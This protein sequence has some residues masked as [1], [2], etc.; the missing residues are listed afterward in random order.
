MS[1]KGCLGVLRF[2][3]ILRKPGLGPRLVGSPIAVD[4][5]FFDLGMALPFL[6]LIPTTLTIYLLRKALGQSQQQLAD[7]CQLPPPGI[8][9]LVRFH[10]PGSCCI[11]DTY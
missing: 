3:G 6:E 2:P 10:S 5:V 7:L 9:F 8:R 4:V 11:P 1:E